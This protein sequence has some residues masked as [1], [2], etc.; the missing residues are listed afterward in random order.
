MTK[1]L[2]KLKSAYSGWHNFAEETPTAPKADGQLDL[3]S[4]IERLK[5]ELAEAKAKPKKAKLEV[6]E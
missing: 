3:A 5:A 6:V 1:Q 2:E 4:E